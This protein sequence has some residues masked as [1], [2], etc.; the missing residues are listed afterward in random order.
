[1]LIRIFMVESIEIKS[2]V[3][4]DIYLFMNRHKVWGHLT[5]VVFAWAPCKM[6]GGQYLPPP[7]KG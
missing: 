5:L 1:M 3:K 4:V 7:S 6:L 2:K